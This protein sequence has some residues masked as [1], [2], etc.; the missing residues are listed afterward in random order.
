M[1]VVHTRDG[2]IHYAAALCDSQTH[3]THQN[4][5]MCSAIAASIIDVFFPLLVFAPESSLQACAVARYCTLYRRV[6]ATDQRWMRHDRADCHNITRLAFSQRRVCAATSAS[7]LSPM[8][9]VWLTPRASTLVIYKC[10][11]QRRR[12]ASSTTA[13]RV[14]PHVMCCIYMMCI[15]CACDDGVVGRRRLVADTV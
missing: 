5:S 10:G 15:F 12:L 8:R 13:R 6:R 4:I 1:C 11:A 14:R 3:K 9:S 2:L 7:S